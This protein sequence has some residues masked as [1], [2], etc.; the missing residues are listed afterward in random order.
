M[1]EHFSLSFNCSKVVIGREEFLIDEALIS[2]VTEL[3]CTRE[4]WFKTT[5]PKDMEFRSY[6]KPEHRGI[7]WK[8]FVPSSWLEENWQQLLK[9]IL[10]YLTYEGRY[11]RA[12]IYHFKLMN[13][14]TGKNPLNM[15]FYLHRSLGKM[16]HQVKSQPSKIAIRLCHHGLIQLLVQE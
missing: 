8:K 2:E 1:V 6:L 4:K 15:P 14:F 11:N 13:H 10:V 9:S 3:P 12:M 7:T 5:I 16:A